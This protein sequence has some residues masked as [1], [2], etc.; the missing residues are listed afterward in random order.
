MA[1]NLRN[2]RILNLKMKKKDHQADNSIL[3]KLKISMVMLIFKFLCIKSVILITMKQ[4]HTSL[5]PASLHYTLGLFFEEA[6]M[7]SLF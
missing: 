1:Q 2:W 5:E 3:Q 7:L 6:P 4:K